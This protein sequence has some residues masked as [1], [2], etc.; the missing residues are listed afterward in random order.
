MSQPIGEAQVGVNYDFLAKALTMQGIDEG[1]I[2]VNQYFK[3]K[4]VSLREDDEFL[5]LDC[6]VYEEKYN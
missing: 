5:I 3:V 6:D 1:S 4:S 2:E